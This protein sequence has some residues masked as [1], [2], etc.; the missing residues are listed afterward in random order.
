MVE[1]GA[2]PALLALCVLVSGCGGGSSSTPGTE[3]ASASSAVPATTSAKSTSPPKPT[4]VSRAQLIEIADGVCKQVKADF[5]GGAAGNQFA[6]I[7]QVASEH[8]VIEERA[9][10]DLAALV[11]PHSLAVRWRSLV[12][13]RRV[14]AQE[15]ATLS[16]A[17][18]EEDAQAIVRL[19]RSKARRTKTVTALAKGLGVGECASYG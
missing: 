5:K 19:Q 8:A 4:K 12:V 13:N 18:H 10:A 9:A 11:P 1:R 16:Q 2:A 17:A 6:E 15:L 3:S 14:L 7:A